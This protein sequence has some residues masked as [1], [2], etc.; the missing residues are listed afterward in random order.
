MFEA[1]EK[2]AMR[3]LLYSLI[4]RLSAMI[5]VTSMI[6]SAVAINYIGIGKKHPHGQES[7]GYEARRFKNLHVFSAVVLK[8]LLI[9][10]GGPRA[11]A[12]LQQLLA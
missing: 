2:P 7:Q 12:R 8:L 5:S 10:H 9:Y 3:S 6:L 11:H 1:S 4:V